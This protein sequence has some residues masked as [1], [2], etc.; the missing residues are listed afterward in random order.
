MLFI[1]IFLYSSKES[2]IPNIDN[3]TL[4]SKDLY[5]YAFLSIL[6]TIHSASQFFKII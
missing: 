3:I 6:T 5:L 4:V 1:P 2:L